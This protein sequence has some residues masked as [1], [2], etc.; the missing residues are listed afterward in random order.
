MSLSIAKIS[1]VYQFS[2]K[3]HSLQIT[4]KRLQIAGTQQMPVRVLFT[5]L[6]GSSLWTVCMTFGICKR[7]ALVENGFLGLHVRSTRRGM[8]FRSCVMCVT[9]FIHVAHGSHL[10]FYFF[11]F[12]YFILFDSRHNNKQSPITFLWLISFVQFMLIN[13]FTMR[14]GRYIRITR[15]LL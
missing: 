3:T 9:F 6:Y 13:L 7:K 12:F 2:S 5:R 10:I 1:W 8:E 14:L 11:F 4:K 15:L